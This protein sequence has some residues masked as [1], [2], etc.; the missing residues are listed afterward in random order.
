MICQYI[1][2]C[3]SVDYGHGSI[4]TAVVLK[5]ANVILDSFPCLSQIF[6]FTDPGH[7]FLSHF[8]HLEALHH[9]V[10]RLAG[11]GWAA[12]TLNLA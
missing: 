8:H 3:P 5:A 1:S 4:V 7:Q 6:P 9:I 10:S 2:C 11:N 12:K